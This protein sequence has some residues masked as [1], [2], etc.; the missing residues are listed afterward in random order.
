MVVRSGSLESRLRA[1]TRQA[2]K[3]QEYGRLLDKL[4][5]DLAEV[6]EDRRLRV[7]VDFHDLYEYLNLDLNDLLSQDEITDSVV[8]QYVRILLFHRLTPPPIF[9]PWYF[10][11]FRAVLAKRRVAFN[12]VKGRIEKWAGRYEAFFRDESSSPHGFVAYL[13][14]LGRAGTELAREE[15]EARVGGFLNRVRAFSGSLSATLRAVQFVARFDALVTRGRLVGLQEGMGNPDRVMIERDWIFDEAG[16]ILD[17]FRPGRVAVNNSDALTLSAIVQLNNRFAARGEVVLMS[18]AGL[19]ARVV[20]RLNQG[21]LR[22]QELEIPTRDLRYWKMF[23]LLEL[24]SEQEEVP[25]Q[26]A[27]ADLRPDV[28]G[29]VRRLNRGVLKFEEWVN[30]SESVSDRNRRRIEKAVNRLET[31][32]QSFLERLGRPISEARSKLGL[33]EDLLT[34]LENEQADLQS[35]IRG[36]ERAAKA[37]TDSEAPLGAKIEELES[38][39]AAFERISAEVVASSGVAE[40]LLLARREDFALRTL[41]EGFGVPNPY[42]TFLQ[43]LLR[44]GAAGAA[45]ALEGLEAAVGSS[46]GGWEEALVR[47]R[48]HL[49]TGDWKEAEREFLSKSQIMPEVA[50]VRLTEALLLIEKSE[51]SSALESLEELLGQGHDLAVQAFMAEAYCRRFEI[52]GDEGDREEALGLA[53]RVWRDSPGVSTVYRVKGAIVY[54]MLR[55]EPFLR[56]SDRDEVVGLIRLAAAEGIAEEGLA[57]LTRVLSDGTPRS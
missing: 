55:E 18:S 24:L 23:Y 33:A 57:A 21:S 16:L 9:L 7:C 17:R 19:M 43:R 52:G 3:L 6:S 10:E 12:E 13:E 50:E 26:Q 28:E 34:S 47:T 53:W 46:S 29:I 49:A 32:M 2:R 54:F 8:D 44:E 40:E 4:E 11:E 31:E 22:Q 48:A 25:V 5:Q 41:G 51:F 30:R 35:V 14:A 42:S 1:F 37:I 20:D 15:V 39:L 38:S 45:D 36:L 56:D 27:L